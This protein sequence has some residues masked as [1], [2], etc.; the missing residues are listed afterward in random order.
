MMNTWGDVRFVLRGFRQN[1]GF[2]FTAAV[3]I[4]V[5]VGA[6]TAM[7]S[8]VNTVM[9]RPL[10][11]PDP[12]RLVWVGATLPSI[13]E[14]VMIG[15]D[16]LELRDRAESFETYAGYAG[17]MPCDITGHGEPEH[18]QCAGATYNIFDVLGVR[19]FLGRAFSAAEDRPGGPPVVVLTY[20]FWQRR[21]GGDPRALGQSITIDGRPRTIVGVL[22]RDFRSPY[23][24]WPDAL[25]PLA[26]NEAEQSDRRRVMILQSVARLK[27]GVTVEQ[28]RA[29]ATAIFDSI[30]QRYPRFYR[31]GMQLGITPLR[32]YQTRNVRLALSVLLA[33]VICVLAIACA[34]VANLLL[35]RASRRRREIAVRASLG[36]G[37]WRIARQLLTESILLGAIGGAA[38]LALVAAATGALRRFLPPDLPH[39][40]DLAIDVQVLLFALAASI[41]TGI[42]FGL[43]PAFTAARLDLYEALKDGGESRGSSRGRLRAALVVAEIAVSTAVVAGA[44]L[45]LQ[46]LWRIESVKTGFRA[47]NVLTTPLSLPPTRYRTPASQQQFVSEVERRVAAVPGVINVALGTSLPPADHM[48]IIFTVVRFEGEPPFDPRI[49][50][51]RARLAAVTPVYFAALGIPLRQGRLL[52]VADGEEGRE[53]VVVNEAFVRRFSPHQNP[54]GRRLVLGGAAPA[55]IAGVVADVKNAGLTAEVDPQIYRPL[56]SAGRMV[57]FVRTAQRPGAAADEIRAIVRG[58]DPDLPLTFQTLEDHLAN[59]NARPRFQ[60]TVLA[61]FAAIA[62]LLAAI[63]IFGVMSYTVSQRTREIGIRMTLGA[64]PPGI[65]NLVVGQALAL[66]AAGVA[67]GLAMAAMLTRFLASMLYG[68]PARDAASFSLSAA[69]LAAVAVAAS[70][71]PARRA[72]RVDPAV[73]LRYE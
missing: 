14:E 52:T 60:T 27:P 33:A 29:E 19:P 47:G 58:L 63:G 7:F 2:F 40:H 9:L 17:G 8:V 24:D 1:P 49:P 70:Y 62:L 67:I 22:P 55:T 3:V 71:I 11:Y 5:G 54:L 65:R 37:R 18:A 61:A 51:N 36:A 48:G 42:V 23:T 64:A 68:V 35:A 15:P 59:L 31:A 72:S 73:A 39:A 28:A 25:Q 46:S 50:A 66:T 43:A 13:P 26:I 57:L 69:I 12:G 44:A 6:A 20:A 34:N 30:K 53:A 38:G 4:A 45:L 21:F 16:Y 10:P 41:V 32:E 56:T